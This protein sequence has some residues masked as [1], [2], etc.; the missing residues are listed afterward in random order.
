MWYHQSANIAELFDKSILYTCYSMNS[1]RILLQD[2][3]TKRR[4][5][6]FYENVDGTFLSAHRRWNKIRRNCIAVR[7]VTASPPWIA[8]ETKTK[9]RN[10]KETEREEA[11]FN[12]SDLSR[13]KQ[14]SSI[15]REHDARCFIKSNNSFGE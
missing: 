10:V 9:G 8:N 12:S 4:G 3:V 1:G 14:R 15:Y 7:C 2:D 13:K 6:E 11:S 5:R